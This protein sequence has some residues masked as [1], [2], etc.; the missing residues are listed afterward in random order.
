MEKLPWVCKGNVK[1]RG[2]TCPSAY[3]CRCQVYSHSNPRLYR[4][5][6]LHIKLDSCIWYSLSSLS[7]LSIRGKK[8]KN[9]RDILNI[10]AVQTTLSTWDH[11]HFRKGYLNALCICYFCIHWHLYVGNKIWENIFKLRLV[12][13]LLCYSTSLF[14][15]HS[16]ISQRLNTSEQ[17]MCEGFDGL[18][19]GCTHMYPRI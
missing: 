16:H 17:C 8:L 7:L 1:P 19:I 2:K 10:K 5:P 15:L 12:S 4:D 13:S 9:C 6:G 3:D 11:R 18:F 14:G